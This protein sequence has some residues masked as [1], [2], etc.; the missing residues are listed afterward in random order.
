M[1]V[2]W[3][4]LFT[5]SLYFNSRTVVVEGKGAALWAR[6]REMELAAAEKG[7]MGKTGKMGRAGH[8]QI[9]LHDL[10]A[11]ACAAERRHDGPASQRSHPKLRV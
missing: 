5:N 6:E 11:E 1:Y 4:L 8:A 2:T 10:L 9:R 7:G 3:L